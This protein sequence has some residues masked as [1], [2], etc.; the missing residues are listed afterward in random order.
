MEDTKELTD[1]ESLFSDELKCQ[2]SHSTTGNTKCSHTVVGRKLVSCVGFDFF[3]CQV[4]YKTNADAMA[5]L[6]HRC[7]SCHADSLECWTLIPI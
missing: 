3:V 6:T 1:L 7:N 5:D 2:S 4:S